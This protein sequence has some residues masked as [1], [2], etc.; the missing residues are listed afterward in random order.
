MVLNYRCKDALC[1]IIRVDFNTKSVNVENFAEDVFYRPFGIIEN[2]SF[3][4]FKE[5]LEERCFPRTRHHVKYYL[6]KLGLY[7][8]DPLEIV[9]K[10]NGRVYGDNFWIEF[11]EDDN[12][13]VL[14]E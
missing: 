13:E 3:E 11:V 14:Y 9:R 8:Y 4:D 7:F 6:K 10:T 1:A 12:M 5:L 2:P